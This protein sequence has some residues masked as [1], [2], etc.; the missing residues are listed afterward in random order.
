ME[1]TLGPVR[2]HDCH[3]PGMFRVDGEWRERQ[4]RLVPGS[5]NHYLSVYV[6]HRCTARPG[7]PMYEF[8]R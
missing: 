2:C 7:E 3:L 6:K 8:T 5:T 4:W 1:I